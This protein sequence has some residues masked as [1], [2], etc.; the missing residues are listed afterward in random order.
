MKN[1]ALMTIVVMALALSACSGN[2]VPT[3]IPTVVLGGS[4]GGTGQQQTSPSPAATGGVTASGVVVPEPKASL[5][6]PLTGTVKTVEVKA[7]DK[8]TKGQTLVTLDTTVL[9]AQVKQAQA[10][11]TAAQAQVK[12]LIRIGTDQE[13]IDAANADVQQA[14]ATLDAANAT[15]AEATLTAPFDGTIASLDTAVAETVVPGQEV[16]MIGNLSNFRVETTDLSERDAPLV[17]I[18]QN[19]TVTVTALNQQ[20]P[21]KVIDISRVSSTVGGDVV[22]KVTIQL[23][24]QPKGLLWGMTTD[25]AI[26][27]K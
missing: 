24:A 9:D 21:G 11:L 7:G 27:T 26:Q 10:A 3:P 17:Q 2:S 15:V 23:D 5:S 12:Y 1:I 18:G 13:H 25:V 8:V 4:S 16:I 6:F 20:F 19:A 14:Q 22:Y